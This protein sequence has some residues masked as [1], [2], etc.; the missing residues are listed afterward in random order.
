MKKKKTC[1]VKV[2]GM[3]MQSSL[4]AVRKPPGL[5]ERGKKKKAGVSGG[6]V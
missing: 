1:V 6:E 2:T 3:G 4:L 5:L